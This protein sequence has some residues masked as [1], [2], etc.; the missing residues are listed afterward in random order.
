VIVVDGYT[1]VNIDISV[2]CC[3]LCYFTC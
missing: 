2:K 3:N 1:A